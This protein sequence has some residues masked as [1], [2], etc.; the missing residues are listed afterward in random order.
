MKQKVC[1]KK[2]YKKTFACQEDEHLKIGA[3]LYGGAFFL[4][5]ASFL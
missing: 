2:G 3:I 5:D 1:V 4:V